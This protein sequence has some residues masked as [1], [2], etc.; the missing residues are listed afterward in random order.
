LCTGSQEDAEES[1]E[2]E[3]T[4]TEDQGD[5]TPDEKEDEVKV[6]KKLEVLGLSQSKLTI[7]NILA[8]QSIS[9]KNFESTR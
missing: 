2:D 9:E 1:E 6:N 8:F 5:E 7:L 4:E 3:D